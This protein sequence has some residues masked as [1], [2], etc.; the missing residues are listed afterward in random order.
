MH[1]TTGDYIRVDIPDR[2]DPDFELHG[3]QGTVIAVFDDDAGSETGDIRD[4]QPYPVE[5]D[6]GASFNRR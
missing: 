6:D 4:S 3:E 5:I 1:F 2:D